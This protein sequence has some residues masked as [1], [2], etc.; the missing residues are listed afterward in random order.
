MRTSIRS[1]ARRTRLEH[2]HGGAGRVVDDGMAEAR[3]DANR[4]WRHTNGKGVQGLASGGIEHTDRG[5]AR[6]DDEDTVRAL[7]DRQRTGLKADRNRAE[8]ATAARIEHTHRLMIA[9]DDEQAVRPCTEGQR[10]GPTTGDLDAGELRA[11]TGVPHSD[12]AVCRAKDP[13]G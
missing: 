11:T 4:D 3:I 12:R 5:A 6:I 1:G 10:A 2:A 8:D 9:V 13:A 7:I